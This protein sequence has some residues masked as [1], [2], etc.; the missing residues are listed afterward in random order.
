MVRDRL[1]SRGVRQWVVGPS[2]LCAACGAEL[3]V[4]LL[5][6]ATQQF[7]LDSASG[8]V[9]SHSTTLDDGVW[10]TFVSLETRF[11]W[12]EEVV[13]LDETECHQGPWCADVPVVVC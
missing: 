4:S 9:P 10:E 3:R 7:Y 5:R 2:L 6:R 1:S 13:L 8:V 11:D 12:D